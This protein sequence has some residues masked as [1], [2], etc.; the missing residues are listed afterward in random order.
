MSCYSDHLSLKVI[1]KGMPRDLKQMG[2]KETTWNLKN[3]EVGMST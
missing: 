1:F 3:M 2:E